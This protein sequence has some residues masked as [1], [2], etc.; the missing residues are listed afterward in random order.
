MFNFYFALFNVLISISEAQSWMFIISY[1]F[2]D[3]LII[4]LQV[5]LFNTV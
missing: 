4:F 3:G 1:S 5:L 2:F